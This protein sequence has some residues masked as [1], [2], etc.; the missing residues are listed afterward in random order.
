MSDRLL[1]TQS[2]Q[3]VAEYFFMTENEWDDF[4]TEWDVDEDV[5]EYAEKAFHSWQLKVAPAFSDLSNS[6]VL[7]FGCGT[8]LLAEKLA[9]KCGQVVAIDSSP[10][11]IEVLNNKIEQST[12]ANI[13]ASDLTVNTATIRD[14]PVFA[15]RFDL[16]VAS[17]VCSFLPDYKSTLCD[18]SLLLKPNGWFVQ[19][20]WISDMPEERIRDAFKMCGLFEQSI[21]QS[22]SM[23]SNGKA[24]PVVMG[25]GRKRS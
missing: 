25:I 12:V 21:E 16:I 22:F 1:V 20:D 10:K 5:R 13:V 19:W 24:T 4:A 3:S 15:D 2:S 23:E 7:D 11:M 9:A 18:L 8:G 6:R 17:S 14:H